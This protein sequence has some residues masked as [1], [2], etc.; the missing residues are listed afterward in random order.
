MGDPD[1][2]GVVRAWLARLF[3]VGVSRRAGFVCGSATIPEK[4]HTVAWSLFHTPSRV[5]SAKPAPQEYI[6]R[7]PRPPFGIRW[8]FDRSSDELADATQARCSVTSPLSP[9]FR[10]LSHTD[11]PTTKH[12]QDP[13]EDLL[14]QHP[15]G[16]TDDEGDPFWSG[17]R[18]PPTPLKLDSASTMHREFVWW[19]SV[20]RAEV[21]GLDVPRY[22]RT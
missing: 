1:S 13:A 14:K 10:T 3:V 2:R 20:L 18:R 15:L 11:P 4:G 17:V 22:M 9:P 7:G 6:H 8:H 12:T 16:S 5:L 19:A 21:Y